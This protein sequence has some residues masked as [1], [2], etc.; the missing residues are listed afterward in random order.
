MRR[1]RSWR[2]ETGAPLHRELPAVQ[3]PPCFAG[4]RLHAELHQFDDPNRLECDAAA[5]DNREGMRRASRNLF[6]LS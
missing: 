2:N 3:I 5:P 1:L 4:F 6:G